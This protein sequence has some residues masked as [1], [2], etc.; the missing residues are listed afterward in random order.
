[1]STTCFLEASF[2]FTAF[3]N[4]ELEHT[5]CGSRKKPLRKTEKL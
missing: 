4:A 3:K 1:M 2:V 5:A